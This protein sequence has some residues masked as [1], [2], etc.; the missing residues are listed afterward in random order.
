[1]SNPME[2][3]T[4]IPVSN[5][6]HQANVIQQKDVASMYKMAMQNPQAFEEQFKR[7][8]PQAYEQAI[9]LAKSRNPKD[10]VMQILNKRG[11]NP[12]SFM[13]NR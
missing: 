6:S 13:L 7:A 9:A 2:R 4:Y 11:I 10:I 5:N 1:M 8:N 3:A 12:A